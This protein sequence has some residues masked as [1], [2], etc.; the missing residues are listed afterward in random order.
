MKRLFAIALSL[1]ALP[2]LAQAV[3]PAAATGVAGV[4]Q[5]VADPLTDLLKMALIALTG[6]GFRALLTLT[7]NWRFGAAIASV[8]N[9]VQNATKHLLEGL[10]PDIK[11][12]LQNDGVIDAN[13]RK[14]LITKALAL[15]EAELP[16]WIQPALSSKLGT[17]VATYL[18]GMVASALDGHLTALAAGATA[19]T[20]STD[21]TVVAPAAS[22]P[23][24]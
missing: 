2:A 21:A 6:L 18:S 16:A 22:A 24:P 12:D 23:H 5:T 1:L 7:A 3:A 11:A 14:A 8:T 15:L 9:Y 4:L 13:E 20:K 10:A 19:T 17:G